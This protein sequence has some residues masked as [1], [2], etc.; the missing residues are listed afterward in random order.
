MGR[1]GESAAQPCVGPFSHA[2]CNSLRSFC[3][4]LFADDVAVLEGPI[5]TSAQGLHL[6][7]NLFHTYPGY[8]EPSLS[9]LSLAFITLVCAG[10]SPLPLVSRLGTGIMGLWRFDD[11]TNSGLDS[12]Q[13]SAVVS[14][15]VWD[16]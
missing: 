8:R 5:T 6:A 15:P 7:S 1:L 2:Q 9:P 10:D 13:C 16:F 14:R 3:A 11:S 12:G 4:C